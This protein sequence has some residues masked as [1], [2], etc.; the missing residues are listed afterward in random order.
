VTAGYLARYLFDC[1]VQ[2][3]DHIVSLRPELGLPVSRN[4]T[5]PFVSRPV[6]ITA[7]GLN[8]TPFARTCAKSAGLT[9]LAGLIQ[10]MPGIR[11][12]VSRKALIALTDWVSKPS[13]PRERA[14]PHPP[15]LL[16][17]PC[18]SIFQPSVARS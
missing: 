16:I 18:R 3:V 11:W 14:E 2:C 15:C 4:T 17:R 9:G 10:R 5:S 12:R 6:A 7:A 13:C 1:R 8:F